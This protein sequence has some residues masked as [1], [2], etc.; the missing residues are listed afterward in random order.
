MASNMD[1]IINEKQIPMHDLRASDAG[2]KN[3]DLDLQGLHYPKH[4]QFE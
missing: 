3:I 4:R 1:K 2:Q